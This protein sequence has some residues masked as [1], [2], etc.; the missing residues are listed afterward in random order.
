MKAPTLQ[1]LIEARYA[2]LK[3]TDPDR[4]HRFEAALFHRIE[5]GGRSFTLKYVDDDDVDFYE[6][7]TELLGYPPIENNNYKKVL[8]IRWR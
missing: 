7:L 2:Y 8:T 5:T 4:I 3:K 6:R 1:N